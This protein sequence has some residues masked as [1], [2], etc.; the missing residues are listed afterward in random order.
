MG[1]SVKFWKEGSGV[2]VRGSPSEVVRVWA[3]RFSS[4]GHGSHW[5]CGEG[6]SPCFT[7]QS[8]DMT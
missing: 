8:S 3:S 4:L 7:L 5:H 2:G 1:A 6:Q